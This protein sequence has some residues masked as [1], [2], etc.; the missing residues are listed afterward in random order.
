VEI[1]EGVLLTASPSVKEKLSS[2][3]KAGFQLAIDQFGTGYSS[4]TYLKKFDIDYLKIDRSFVHDMT[5]NTNSRI[6]TETIIAMA[7]KLGLK[8]IAE[9]VETLEQRDWLKTAQCDYAQGYL[10]SKPVCSQDF[11]K[12]LESQSI[13]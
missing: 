1:T 8:V 13:H 9:G 4:M 5:T 7:H 3:Q 2:L 12:L 10:F 11:E 6:I